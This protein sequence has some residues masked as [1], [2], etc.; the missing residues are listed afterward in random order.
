MQTKSA[1]DTANILMKEMRKEQEAAKLKQQREEEEAEESDQRSADS[2]MEFP[3]KP[4]PRVSATFGPASKQPTNGKRT[5]VH[6]T[7][8]NTKE[9]PLGTIEVTTSTKPFSN[10]PSGSNKRPSG[11]PSKASDWIEGSEGPSSSSLSLARKVQ[12]PKQM[13]LPSSSLSQSLSGSQSQSQEKHRDG[14]AAKVLDISIVPET[15]ET[16]ST[17]SKSQSQPQGQSQSQPLATETPPRSQASVFEPALQGEPRAETQASPSSPPVPQ[18]SI[19]PSPDAPPESPR[20]RDILSGPISPLTSSRTKSKPGPKTKTL[21]FRPVPF[22]TPSRFKSLVKKNGKQGD[23]DPPS[24]PVESFS[25][26]SQNSRKQRD[27][28]M[29]SIDIDSTG[30][31]L[32]KS[33]LESH[34]DQS[35]EGKQREPSIGLDDSFVDWSGGDADQGDLG[36]NEMDVDKRVDTGARKGV[37]NHTEWQAHEEEEEEEEEAEDEAEETKKKVKRKRTRSLSVKRKDR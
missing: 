30:V 13:K 17:S 25:T 12:T 14:T 10:P 6:V 1:K 35:Q 18:I 33:T 2:G 9:Q 34:V 21:T 24:S 29:E 7:I 23:N 19:H 26:P 15:Q 31:S 11:S 36:D 3:Q 8:V 37:S 5:N 20:R 28:G 27:A 16:P 4:K 22:V 32:P